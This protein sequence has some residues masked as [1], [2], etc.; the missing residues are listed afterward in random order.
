MFPLINSFRR[1]TSP[2]FIV[3]KCI[4]RIISNKL[5]FAMV[6]NLFSISLYFIRN[7]GVIRGFLL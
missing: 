2:D 3:A 6:S 1:L 5:S 7:I 4:V